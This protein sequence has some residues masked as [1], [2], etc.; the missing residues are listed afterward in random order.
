LTILYLSGFPLIWKVG[1]FITGKKKNDIYQ[2][3][4]HNSDELC[5]CCC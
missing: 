2:Q 3:Q 1:S 4:S 5:D